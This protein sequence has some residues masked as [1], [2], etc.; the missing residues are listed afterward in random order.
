MSGDFLSRH[1]HS[2]GIIRPSLPY[3]LDVG[4]PF[5]GA[6]VFMFEGKLTSMNRPVNIFIHLDVVTAP[7][8]Y[9]D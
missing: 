3:A 2:N 8:P 6:E 7:T 1:H 5:G 4:I 9:Y